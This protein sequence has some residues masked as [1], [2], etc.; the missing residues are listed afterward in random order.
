MRR[1]DVT[2][3][4]LR[5]EAFEQAD[6]LIGQAQGTF[7]SGLFQSQQAFVLGQ[8][9]VALP[10]AAHAARRD[11]DAAQGEFLRDA[12]RAVTGLRQGVVE[13]GLLDLGGDAVGMRADGRILLDHTSAPPPN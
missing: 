1:L 4:K 2:F 5:A 13:N 7:G 3:A 9:S 8:Q 10:D 12:H 11:L 6:L